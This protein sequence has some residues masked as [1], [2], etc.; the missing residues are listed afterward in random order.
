M[1]LPTP[2]PNGTCLVTG[3][4]SGIGADVARELAG[5]GYNVTLA[6][7]RSERLEDLAKEITDEYEVEATAVAC[8][9][10]DDPQV[11]KL[12]AGIAES[13]K[14]IDILVNNAGVG[15]EGRFHECSYQSQVGQVELNC[16]TVVG[17]SHR[18]LGEMVERGQGGILITASTAAFQPMPRQSV[19][20]ATK[21]FVLSFGEALHQEYSRDGIVVTTL[22]P[23][24]T[25]TEFFGEKMDGYISKTPEV[26][27]QTAAEVAKAGVDGLMRGK[28][29][30]IPSTINRLSALSGTFSPHFLSLRMVDKFW[31][32]G[33]E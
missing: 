16:R 15:S 12:L 24:P 29:V 5:R 28:R 27:W 33:K 23:G 10:T 4:S 22:C 19:Y 7:R 11:D 13:G 25:K 17:L 9:V 21:A 8:D 30:V 3:A 32:V 20:A 2:S 31:P 6:A 18:V 14:H 26:A 1:S